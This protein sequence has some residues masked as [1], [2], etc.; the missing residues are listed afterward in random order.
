MLRGM[1]AGQWVCVLSSSAQ[2]ARLVPDASHAPVRG[3]CGLCL[4]EP[5]K[6][7]HPHV[8]HSE[9]D[10]ARHCTCDQGDIPAFYAEHQATCRLTA[11]LLRAA[12]GCM[13]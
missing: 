1:F 11:L 3:Q 7:K 9:K 2:T 6:P 8:Q 10:D 4:D 12:H 13:R 5:A